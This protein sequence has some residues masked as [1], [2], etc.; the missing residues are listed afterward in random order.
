MVGA[1]EEGLEG[2]GDIHITGF[3]CCCSQIGRLNL[4]L[5]MLVFLTNI[6]VAAVLVPAIAVDR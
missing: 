5:F 3:H 2:Q 4:I 6:L 1:R